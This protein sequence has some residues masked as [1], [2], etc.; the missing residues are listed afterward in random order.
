MAEKTRSSVVGIREES[1]EGTLIELSAGAQFTAIREGFSVQGA[2]ETVE[3]DEL[4][5]DI[6]ASAPFTTKETPTASIPKYLKHSGVEGQAP[7]YAVMIKSC[8]GAQTTNGTEYNTVSGSSAGTATAAAVINVDT[9][10]G[11]Q[12]AKGQGL[13]IKDGTNGRKIR[14]VRSISTDA[15]TLNYNLNAA[16]AAGVNLGKAIHFAP[17]VDG[18]PTYSLHHYQGSSSSA[19]HQAVAGCRTTAMSMSFGANELGTVDF[20]VEGVKFF[21]NPIVIGANKHINFKDDTIGSE[22]TA[23]LSE[24]AYQSPKALAE[25][26]AAKMTAASVASEGDTISCSF[27]STTG[28]FTISTS[29]SFLSLLWDSGANTATNAAASLGFSDAADDTAATS[30]VADNVL[31]YSP[32]YTPALDAADPLVIKNQELMIGPFNRTDCRSGSNVSI[33]VNTPKTDVDSFCSETGVSGSVVLGREVSLSTTLTFREHEVDEFHRM[34][35]NE[36]TQCMFNVGSKD[37]NGNWIAGTCINFYMPNAKIV[38][39]LISDADGL[40]IVELEA[41]GFVT[42]DQKDLHIN[43]L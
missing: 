37:S 10:E 29:G 25:E 8:M 17:A 34:M 19:L 11:A 15:L 13:L 2:I 6:G 24:K 42:S 35:K 33:S 7:D 12:F 18:H 5:N 36:T 27:N 9:G 32:A 22:L 20:S 39:H 21:Y 40:M 14:N 38:S 30:Y 28:K 4:V 26:V 23:T 41:R 16:P 31:E 1:A 3:S 43:F